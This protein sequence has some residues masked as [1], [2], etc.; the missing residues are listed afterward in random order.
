MAIQVRADDLHRCYLEVFGAHG[1][2][3][4]NTA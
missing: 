2:P 4:V 1:V 3:R